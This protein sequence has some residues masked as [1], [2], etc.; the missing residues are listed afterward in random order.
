MIRSPLGPSPSVATSAGDQI[1]VWSWDLDE[2][3]DIRVLSRAERERAERFVF[4]HDRR[5]WSASRALLRLTLGR[6]LECDP[7][8]LEF[9]LDPGGKPRL[10]GA[11]DLHFSLSRS[12][13][14]CLLAVT[15]CGPVGADVEILRPIPEALG[16]ARR[17]FASDEAQALAQRPP[18]QLTAAFLKLWVCKEAIV[19]SSGTGITGRLDAFAVEF[20]GDGVTVRVLDGDAPPMPAKLR[21]LPLQHAFAA[22]AGPDAPLSSVDLST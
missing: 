18:D 22:I 19:K 16:I 21:L 3:Q 1:D 9:V 15:R 4:A 12:R 8:A 11:D 2:P 14:Q 13:D 6:V 10:A 17:I 7:S 5:R 20:A